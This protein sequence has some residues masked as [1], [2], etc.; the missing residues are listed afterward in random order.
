M[1]VVVPSER[2]RDLPACR[3][4]ILLQLYWNGNSLY[5]RLPQSFEMNCSL[6][7]HRYDK[8]IVGRYST[9]SSLRVATTEATFIAPPT[10]GSE[11]LSRNLCKPIPCTS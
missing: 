8:R 3:I 9:V 1:V 6:A 4:G 2:C 10:D 11:W 7:M 5:D